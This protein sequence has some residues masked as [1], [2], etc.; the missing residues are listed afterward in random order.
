MLHAR[1]LIREIGFG[2]RLAGQFIGRFSCR[3]ESALIKVENQFASI[4]AKAVS[5]SS[6][7]LS[8]GYSGVA[9]KSTRKMQTRSCVNQIGFHPTAARRRQN[10]RAGS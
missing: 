4:I 8:A 5:Q 2:L 6:V 1:Y 3:M 10:K 7:Q 9:W